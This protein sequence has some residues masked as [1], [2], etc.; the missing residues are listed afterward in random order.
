M[1][2]DTFVNGDLDVAGSKLAVETTGSYGQR[3]LYA[4]ESQQSWFEDFGTTQLSNGV[5]LV[6]FESAFAETVNLGERY[7]IFLTPLGEANLYVSE[8]TATSFTVRPI[9]IAQNDIAFDYRVFAKRR[10]YESVRLE[11]VSL[12]K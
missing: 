3:R 11:Q 7:H 8:K 4:V 12:P 10:G 9:G 2:D 1:G 5:A 6:A